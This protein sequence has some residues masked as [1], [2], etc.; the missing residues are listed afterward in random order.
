MQNWLRQID[1]DEG[2]RPGQ[3][4]SDTGHWTR[5]GALYCC[6]IKDVFSNRVVGHSISNWMTAKLA[7][8]AVRN[9]LARRGDVAGCLLHAARGQGPQTTDTSDP[10]SRSHHVTQTR[11]PIPPFTAETAAR[12][13]QAAE[14]AWNT[15]DPETV[16]QAY[17]VDTAWRNRDQTITGRDQVIAFLA[18][19]WDRELDYQLRKNLWA[20]TDDQIAVRFQYEWHDHDGQWW[21]SYGNELWRF[22]AQGYMTHREA[23][24][25]DRPI[26]QEER[27]VTPG[28]GELPTW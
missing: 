5:E 20:F 1:C 4:V 14:D 16:A 22:D 17:S 2:N 28:H 24:I 6:A 15:R 18:A 3:T 10:R 12:K 11:N 13:V 7:V 25:N 23:S 26:G 21:R 19:K 9:A 8:D 27:R